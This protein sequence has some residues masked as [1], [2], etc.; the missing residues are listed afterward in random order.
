MEFHRSP[1]GIQLFGREGKFTVTP[2][3]Y[4]RG[5]PKEDPCDEM[6]LCAQAMC[7][8]EMLCCDIPYGYL[9]YGE[10]R[11]RIKVEFDIEL[12]CKVRAAVQ[13]MHLLFSRRHTPKVKRTKSCNAC[14]LKDICLPVI[15][16]GISASEYI[17]DC[18]KG[19]VV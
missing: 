12:R 5:E 7:L 8:E 17:S 19:E 13:E 16:G 2:I 14:S 10:K 1:N 11:R 4:K 9:Y 6:Q 18:L 15:C 3:E